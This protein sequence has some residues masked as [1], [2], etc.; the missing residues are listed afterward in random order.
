MRPSSPILLAGLC[1]ITACGDREESVT[2]IPAVRAASPASATVG[3]WS[4]II[5]WPVASVHAQLLPDGR[6]LA[7]GDANQ[8]DSTH[9]DAAIWDPADQS[10]MLA[11]STLVNVFCSGH[12]LLPDG[13]L[14]VTGGHKPGGPGKRDVQTFDPATNSWAPAG[15]MYEG[16][17]YPTNVTLASGNVA[18]LAGLDG[19]GIDNPIP[20]VWT[21]GTLRQLKGARRAIY[22]YPWAYLAP[23]GRVF[24]AGPNQD[25]KY[26]TTTG[27][28][29]WAS[30]PLS[31]MPLR[32]QGTSVMFELGK[33]LMVGGGSV[34]VKTGERLNI[35]SPGKQWGR[36]ADMNFARRQATATV[37]PDGQVLV[38]GGSSAAGFNNV[39]GAVLTPER[40]DPVGNTWSVLAPHAVSRLYH[41]VSVLL[42]DGRVWVG[43]GTD[44]PMGEPVA[45]H[46]NAEIFSPPYLFE[47]DGSLAPRPAITA[48]PASATWGQ[49][50]TVVTPDSASISKVSITRLAAVTHTFSQD[51][52][53]MKL[54]F[55]GTPGGLAVQIPSNPNHLPP[56]WY[57][58]FLLDQAG[59]PSVGHILRIS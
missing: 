41:S 37:L 20:E 39:A 33:I 49:A 40:W 50:I 15:T 26:L 6:L 2:A 25:S 54:T 59:R 45:N 3:E 51:N 18:V 19:R 13:R 55:G 35:M 23:D 47:S 56:G 48:A 53:F 16:R 24:H 29:A 21:N 46:Q 8:D 42:P 17:W 12:S 11:P 7:W 10:F 43:G 22:Y 31:S 9:Q 38:V 32:N 14:L 30:G 4:P 52:R 58:L 57:L 5:P 27:K 1:L 44:D 28:G 34:P 36:I